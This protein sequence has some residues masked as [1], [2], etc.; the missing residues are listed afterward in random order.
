V[1]SK[2]EIDRIQNFLDKVEYIYTTIDNLK[3]LADY[4]NYRYN[5]IVAGTD[6]IISGSSWLN[7]LSEE[8]NT[9]VSGNL[10]GLNNWS[11]ITSGWKDLNIYS[12]L[13]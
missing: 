9:M 13:V 3:I 6:S 8:G 5:K 2:T 7:I 10:S 1:S 4:L 12:E 11:S